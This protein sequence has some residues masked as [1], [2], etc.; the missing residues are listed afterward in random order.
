MDSG[1]TKAPSRGSNLRL[2]ELDAE[3]R[4]ARERYRL[5][6][7]KAYGPRLTSAGRLRELERES[8]LAESRLGRAKADQDQRDSVRPRISGASA[9]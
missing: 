7:A 9:P 3:A 6:R 4:H 1:T 2:A 5:Y 8:K